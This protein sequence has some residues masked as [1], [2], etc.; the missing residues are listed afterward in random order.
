MTRLLDSTTPQ[1]LFSYN[2][3]TVAGLSVLSNLEKIALIE[4]GENVKARNSYKL[5]LTNSIYED[6]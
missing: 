1:I 6:K 4:E 3:T 5:D 2:T